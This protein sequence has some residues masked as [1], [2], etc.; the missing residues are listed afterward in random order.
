MKY[1]EDIK[2][3]PKLYKTLEEFI[4]EYLASQESRVAIGVGNHTVQLT[5]V[6]LSGSSLEPD[7]IRFPDYI[8]S[9]SVVA[10]DD[11]Y[12]YLFP[13]TKARTNELYIDVLLLRSQDIRFTHPEHPKRVLRVNKPSLI[14]ITTLADNPTDGLQRKII[15]DTVARLLGR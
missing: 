3:N 6:V 15:D 2:R 4:V 12:E 5:G 14:R 9:D 7:Y 8:I 11:L 13:S 1:R 10:S